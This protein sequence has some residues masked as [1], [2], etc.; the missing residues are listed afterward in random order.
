VFN[1]PLQGSGTRAGVDRGFYP[2]AT[3]LFGAFLAEPRTFGVTLRGRL[4]FARPE[5]VEY[6]PPP[7]PPPPPPAMQTC[8]DGSSVAADAACP[9]PPPPPPPPAPVER[10]ERG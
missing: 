9:P 5:P 10:G 7:A 1:A 3:T 8:P 6:V 2:A 4:G